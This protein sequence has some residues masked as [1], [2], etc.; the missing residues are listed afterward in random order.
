MSRT[1]PL[2]RHL[3]AVL[4]SALAVMAFARPLQTALQE[5]ITPT[6]RVCIVKTF[7]GPAGAVDPIWFL[8]TGAIAL[9]ADGSFYSTSPSGG[10]GF[11]GTI[12]RVSTAGDAKVLHDFAKFD[13]EDGNGPQSG[14]VNGG[15]GY[16]Y[17][18]TYGGGH[19]G[20][21]TLFRIR[22]DQ[23]K[24]EILWHFRNG[25]VVGLWPDC[26]NHLCPYTGR[27]RADI[28]AAYP[29]TPPVVA[30]GGVIY[31]VTS[32]S[33]N[34]GFGVLYRTAPPY[35]ST[36]FH[37]L[38]I[39][40]QRLLADTAMARFVCKAKGFFPNALLLG[41]D[42]SLYGTTL[43][44]NGTVFHA[45]TGG[46]VTNL[47]E[48]AFTDGSKPYNLMQASNGRLYGTTSNG[49]DAGNGTVY[50]LDT[51][52]GGFRVMSS[53]HVGTTLQGL[54]PVG[55]L[56]EVKPPG[57][58]EPF[59]FGTTKF[60][61][62]N[63]RGI[64][65]RIPLGGDSLSLRVLHAFD[66]YTTGRTSVTPQ[67]LAPNGLL[68]GLTYQGGT[69]DDGVLYSL[70]P[71]ELKDQITK[72]T[73]MT[74][75]VL[76]K[77]DEGFQLND[78]IVEMRTRVYASQGTPETSVND[79]IMVRARCTNPHIVQFI[80]RERISPLGYYFPDT[81]ATSA[82]NFPSTTDPANPRWHTDIPGAKDTAYIGRWDAYLDQVRGAAHQSAPNYVTIFDKPSFGAFDDPNRAAPAYPLSGQDS[83]LQ[84]SQTWR[85]TARDF[86]ICNC[87]VAREVH[88]AREVR[89]G[90]A[91]YAHM[92]IFIPAPD[93]LQWIN[94]QLKK[95][96]YAA[97]P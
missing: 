79:G 84:L 58:S 69:Y 90:K 88:W 45:T 38:C 23:T 55:A 15:D 56:V 49:G 83:N 59:L 4:A 37:A 8:N 43:G 46:D 42:G 27:Q 54:N 68:Y 70:N 25:S 60:G 77:N 86:V 11:A 78:P 50:T 47:H 76:A 33:N 1:R 3:L 53:L 96:G 91:Y 22:P 5:P 19:V 7:G 35:D 41:S 95:E 31:G 82:G 39:F 30:P 28:A 62:K 94:D 20:T 51:S 71:M 21:G 67:V 81:V 89:G 63:G 92:R 26:P 72:D 87:Q 75:G 74:G 85:A 40:D 16:F 29:I 44:G 6:G 34:Q 66:M 52:G 61:G 36:S 13:R 18:T 12:F 14:L 32:Y 64:M 9:G 48:F 65:F 57:S 24:P 2:A 97:I 17:G 10:K 93:I 73:Y 80:Q